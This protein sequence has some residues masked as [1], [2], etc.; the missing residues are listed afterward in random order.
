MQVKVSLKMEMDGVSTGIDTCLEV[1]QA[2]SG[3]YIASNPDVSP[4]I[5][6][7]ETPRCAILDFLGNMFWQATR[8]NEP[9]S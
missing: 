3:F 2:P 4:L 8:E 6:H 1:S 9:I 5:G 7:G